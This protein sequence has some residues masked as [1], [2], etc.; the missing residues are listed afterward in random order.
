MYEHY[1]FAQFWKCA[2]QVNP[3]AYSANYRGTDHGMEASTY[4]KS[5]RDTCLTEKIQVVGLADHG[6]VADAETVRKVL[7]DAGVV[8]FPG[9]EVATTGKSPLGMSFP[10]RTQASSNSNATLE[11]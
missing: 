8:V 7:I 2:L 9:F 11:G 5:L 3:H 1:T 6:S 10:G 4:A